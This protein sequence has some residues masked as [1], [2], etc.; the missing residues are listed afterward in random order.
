M[1]PK[2]N[3]ALVFL[4]LFLG[5]SFHSLGQNAY[6]IT[7]QIIDQSTGTP[8]N[9]ASIVAQNTTMGTIS[10]DGG[11]FDLKLPEGGYTISITYAGYV[12]NSFR[13]NNFSNIKDTVIALEPEIKSL[14]EVTVVLDLDREVKDGWQQYGDLF[15]ENFI[16]QTTPAQSCVIRNPE[17]L[18]F[19]YYK[20]R[21]TLKVITKDP[22]IVDNFDLGYTLEFAIDSFTNNFNTHASAFI[23]YPVF[24][25]MLGT[26]KQKEQWEQNREKAYSGSTLQFMRA[27]YNQDLDTAG[28]ELKFIF[29]SATEEIPI[30]VKDVYS[31]LNYAKD[32]NGTLHINPIQKEVAIIYRKSP[33]KAYRQVNPKANRQSQISTFIFDDQQP[34]SIE[35]NGYYYPQSAITTNGYFGFRKVADM[36]PFNYGLPIASEEDIP[37]ADDD[38]TDDKDEVPVKDEVLPDDLN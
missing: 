1:K 17:A 11:F 33:D 25:E 37:E 38:T 7:G 8:L 6:H 4:V 23:G 27:L 21:N 18:H 29:R 22:L 3:F 19:Y 36:L 10:D 28:Y 20:S 12:A 34:L 24:K 26:N 30:D 31:A 15:L 9:A 35:S 2:S 14:Y 32:E 16:G 13:V 5:L